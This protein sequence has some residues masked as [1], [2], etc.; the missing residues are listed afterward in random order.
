MQKHFNIITLIL[1]SFFHQS[2]AKIHIVEPL[3]RS[4][5]SSRP[6]TSLEKIYDANCKHIQINITNPSGAF[7]GADLVGGAFVVTLNKRSNGGT[8]VDIVASNGR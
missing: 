3:S 4:G 6:S 7:T 8:A 2:N 5:K 1:L